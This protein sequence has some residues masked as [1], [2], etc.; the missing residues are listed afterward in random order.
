MKPIPKRKHV[1]EVLPIYL[2]PIIAKASLYPN[3]KEQYMHITY[4]DTE[5]ELSNENGSLGKIIGC[6]GGAIELTDCATHT[7]F[8]ISPKALWESF[9]EALKRHPEYEALVALRRRE[10]RTRRE[11]ETRRPERG[12]R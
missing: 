1:E 2:A 3:C 7:T 6:L 10:E 11:N 9:Q 12:T 8:T 5:V 4:A